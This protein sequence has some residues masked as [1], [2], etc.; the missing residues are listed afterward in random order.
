MGHKNYGQFCDPNLNL[1]NNMFHHKQWHVFLC[2]QL[3][4]GE[5]S[6][7]NLL[8][9]YANSRVMDVCIVIVY[10]QLTNCNLF[11][12]QIV[13]KNYSD[14]E[15]KDDKFWKPLGKDHKL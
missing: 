13:K 10:I 9:R 11:E 6:N 7:C 8:L 14:F 3:V 15:H 4:C 1:N 2:K 5:K 12:R